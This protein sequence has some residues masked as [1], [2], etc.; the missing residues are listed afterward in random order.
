MKLQKLTIHNIASI[1][2]AV[3]DFEEQPLSDSE[4]FLITG[5]TGSGKSTILDAICLALYADTPRLKNTNM[6]GES[7]DNEGTLKIKDPRQLLRRDAGEGWVRLTFIGNNGVH[8]QAEWKVLCAYGKVTGNMQKKQ[9]TLQV[10]SD[11]L[12]LTKDIEIKQ[13]IAK[14]I[15]LDFSQFC[16]T[17]LLAQGDF[18]RFLNSTDD[19]KASILEKLT[20]M[21]VYAKIGQQVYKETGK[22]EKAWQDAQTRTNGIITLDDEQLVEKKDRLTQ[23]EK[24]SKEI[25]NVKKQAENKKQWL[26]T[27]VNLGAKVEN[28]LKEYNEIKDSVETEEFKNQE[29]TVQEWETTIDARRYLNE[30]NKAVEEEKN[31]LFL[32]DNLKK[33]QGHLQDNLEKLKAQKEEADSNVAK[34]EDII[35]QKEKELENLHMAQLREQRDNAKELQ[36]AIVLARTLLQQLS[37]AQTK[38]QQTAENLEK[39]RNK[40]AEMKTDAANQETP[41]LDAKVKMDTAKRLYEEQKDTV[42]KFA[43]A[44]R[45]KLQIGDVCPVCQQKINSALPHEDDLKNLVKNLEKAYTEAEKEYNKLVD[46]KN[47]LKAEIKSEQQSIDFAQDDYDN[48]KSVEK[49]E[50]KALNQLKK[51]KIETISEATDLQLNDLDNQQT[52]ILKELGKKIEEGEKIEEDLRDVL[53]PELEKRR[54]LVD[55][56][57][58]NLNG[59]NDAITDNKYQETT[60]KDKLDS[61]RNLI[62]ENTQS[63]NTFLEKYPEMN[64]TKLAELDK[65]TPEA[66][67]GMR[68]DIN[69]KKN[70]V[71]KRKITWENAKDHLQ[72]HFNTKPLMT[73]EDTL[74]NLEKLIDSNNT[75]L[76]NSNQEIGA[77]KKELE[78]DQMNK[79]KLG[80]LVQEENLAKEEYDKWQRLN[81]LIGN[82]DGKTFRKIAQSYVLGSL[83]HSA[84]SYMRTLTDRYTLKVVPGTFVILLEDAYQGFATRAASTISGGE[85]FLVSLSLALALSDI[86]QKLSVNT[87]F[88]DEGFGTLSGE[89]LQN[90]ITTLRTL[91]DKSGRHVGIISHIEELKERIPVQIQ[92]NQDSGS[93]RSTI[94]IVPEILN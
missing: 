1:E 86:G 3:I 14:A 32:L 17:T 37:E 6:E 44:L 27:E 18:T 2:D 9:W 77:I 85:S 60:A 12:Q 36:S 94:K 8:Y 87:L 28:V 93:S 81:Q 19:E 61:A 92:V 20:G 43:S 90:A 33:K 62:K 39:R 67:L 50:Q 13:E 26:N 35:K 29:K 66:I 54:N 72:E 47:R 74:E 46:N 59:A 10:L 83:I 25:S 34:Q 71:G 49:A 56:K 91:H 22:K 78:T 52:N 75:K 4:V 63:L 68:K 53:R 38:L 58:T 51:C 73:E 65:Y 57:K 79:D 70:E 64:E 76:K 16:R 30:K 11:G 45:Q 69:E 82:A 5:Q 84:N 40:L 31:Q 21:D 89:P 15:E 80:K 7:Q 23:L 41:I 24:D 88:I 42:D 48:D 55:E